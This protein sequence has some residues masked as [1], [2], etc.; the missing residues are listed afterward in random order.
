MRA[1]LATPLLLLAALPTLAQDAPVFRAEVGLVQIEVRAT[2]DDGAPVTDL[3]REDFVLKENGKEH[4]VEAFQFVTGP[5]GR[6]RHEVATEAGAPAV[7][8]EP[9]R[10]A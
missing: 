6:A 7:P 4:P 9:T 3:R 10:G 1:L 5:A 2:D 8:P